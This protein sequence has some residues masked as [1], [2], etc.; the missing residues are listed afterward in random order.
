MPSEAGASAQAVH[1]S[2]IQD[3][4]PEVLLDVLVRAGAWPEVEGVPLGVSKGSP[5]ASA[6]WHWA[7]ER[8]AAPRDMT[9]HSSL[10]VCRQWRDAVKG[11]VAHMAALL[12]EA[13]DSVK[14]ALVGACSIRNE[15]VARHLLELPRLPRLPQPRR[16]PRPEPPRAD[17]LSGRA[18]GAACE[19]GREGILGWKEHAPYSDAERRQIFRIMRSFGQ[20]EFESDEDDEEASD[21][22]DKEEPDES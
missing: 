22:D 3:L 7:Q 9:I 1:Q 12:L 15:A 11:S 8:P 16:H 21:E 17:C 20:S 19:G 10:S 2:T 18:L 14:V 13:H 5:V 4:P 6:S